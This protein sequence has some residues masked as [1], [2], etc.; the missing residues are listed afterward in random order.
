MH[1][2]LVIAMAAVPLVVGCAA[3]RPWPPC[4]R[5]VPRLARAV[6]QPGP[7]DTLGYSPFPDLS[8]Y[9]GSA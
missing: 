4:R 1:R 2:S 6:P 3:Q 9:G 5:H 8:L 7:C